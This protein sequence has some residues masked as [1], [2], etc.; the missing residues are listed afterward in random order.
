MGTSIYPIAKGSFGVEII[1]TINLDRIRYL[2]KLSVKVY[3][4]KIEG[5]YP[6]I[7]WSHGL[8]FN[9]DCYQPLLEFWASHGYILIS[10]N[11][12]D[13]VKGITD[14]DYEVNR[15][16]DIK[17]ILDALDV[18]EK[19]ILRDYYVYID[20]DNIGMGGH[21]LGAHTTQLIGGVEKNNGQTFRDKRPKAFLMISPR[22]SGESLSKDA[23]AKFDR[24]AMVI[25]GTKDSSSLRKKPYTWRMDGFQGMPLNDKYLALVQDAYHGFG[26]ITGIDGW[27]GS[28]PVNRKHVEAVQ[29]TSLIFWNAYLKN[30]KEQIQVLQS[31]FIDNKTE[32]EVLITCK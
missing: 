21:S 7:I 18:I 12:L 30:R 9:K 11:H 1:D 4:P 3:F 5:A 15:T 10:T 28:G 23:W 8:K 31:K 22:G 14:N 27:K 24:P 13:A 16:D 6:V 26:G 17:F 2:Q 32:K 25:V 29:T 19:T 20:R